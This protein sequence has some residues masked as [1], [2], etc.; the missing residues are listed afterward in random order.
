MWRENIKEKENLL[1]VDQ[2]ESEDSMRSAIIS[3]HAK[4]GDL[5]ITTGLKFMDTLIN[6]QNAFRYCH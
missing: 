1:L 2:V 4:Q 6:F 3:S 5:I